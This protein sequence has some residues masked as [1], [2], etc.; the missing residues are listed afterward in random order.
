MTPLD[1]AAPLAGD[2]AE[3]RLT[4]VFTAAL[5]ALKTGGDLELVAGWLRGRLA[6]IA[7]AHPGVTLEDAGELFLRAARDHARGTP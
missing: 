5:H 1:D 6:A 7:A 2:S 3:A 4:R